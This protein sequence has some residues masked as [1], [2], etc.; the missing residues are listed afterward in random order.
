MKRPIL[1]F[2]TQQ[3]GV[4]R[5]KLNSNSEHKKVMLLEQLGL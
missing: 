5:Q 4:V 2:P 3:H 1:N